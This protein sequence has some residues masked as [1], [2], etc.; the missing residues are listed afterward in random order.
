MLSCTLVVYLV[1]YSVVYFPTCCMDYLYTFR[2]RCRVPQSGV[3]L[4]SRLYNCTV[5]CEDRHPLCHARVLL[6]PPPCYSSIVCCKY[7]TVVSYKY[8]PILRC[9]NTPILSCKFTTMVS[10]KY[11]TRVFSRTFTLSAKREC[12]SARAPVIQI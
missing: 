11:R 9:K 2:V 10:C 6:R 3:Q 8:A 4:C 1:V 5:S 7:T 12:S